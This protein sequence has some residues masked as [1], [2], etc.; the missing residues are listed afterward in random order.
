MNKPDFSRMTDAAAIQF[1]VLDMLG[2]ILTL[3]ES[4][5]RMG[6]YLAQQIRELIGARI[7]L[8]L[9][10]RG[11]GESLHHRVL[12]VQPTRFQD[13][14]RLQM[15]G[16]LVPHIRGLDRAVLWTQDEVPEGVRTALEAL[17]SPSAIAVPLTA[18]NQ[19]VGALVA[20]DL[21]EMD[22]SQDVMRSLEILGPVMALVVRNANYYESLE[23]EIQLRTRDLARSEHHFRTLTEVAPVGIFRL[24]GQRRLLFANERWRQITGLPWLEGTDENFTFLIHPAERE[25]VLKE[26]R[27]GLQAHHEFNSEFRLVRGDG[28]EVHVVAQ[29]VG[30]FGEDGGHSGF[31][32]TLTDIS[33]RRRAEEERAKLESHVIQAQKMESIGRLAGGVAHDINNMLAVMMSHLELMGLALPPGQGLQTH[34]EQ[35]GKA[36]ER[37]REIVRQLLAFSRKQVIQPVLFDL[38]ARIEETRRTIAP[39]LGEDIEL[40][41]RPAVG[42]WP[43]RADPGQVDQILINLTVNARDAMPQGGR[44]SLETRNFRMDDRHSLQNY[45][46][47]TGDFV[48]LTVSDSGTGMPPE[49]LAHIFEPF[50]TTKGEGRG[51][52]MGLSTVFGIVKQNGGFIH[53]YSEPGEGSAF[54]VYLPA[55]PEKAIVRSSGEDRASE[56]LPATILVVEDDLFLS[57]VIPTVIESLGYTVLAANSPAQ[58]LE[59]CRQHPGPIHLLLTDVVMPGMSGKEL[60]D[61]LLPIRPGLK[62]LFMS[63]YTSEVITQKGVLDGGIHFIQ[64]PF[65]RVDISHK[66]ATLL[67]PGPPQG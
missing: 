12:T 25:R 21:L 40:H 26:W 19:A 30:L 41:F 34:L 27:D 51:T 32:G 50:Y 42:L 17:G 14:E 24:D 28:S 13:S 11:A 10:H 43:V 22:R 1:M 48:Q 36:A 39:L 33:E 4:P 37:T 18:A 67:R 59:I 58:A 52:G 44:L 23:E 49:I 60:R 8:L 55:E 38:N 61:A 56:A 9:Q 20:L 35:M 15:L 16:A 66:I 31:I 5:S 57:Q 7:V 62:V 6:V 46:G 53:V 63:G 2:N 65:S 45:E 29:A 47:M 64:K 3:A 54:K